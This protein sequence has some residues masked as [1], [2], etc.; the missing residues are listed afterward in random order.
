M[1]KCCRALLEKKVIIRYDTAVSKTIMAKICEICKKG[2][3]SGHHIKHKQAGGW[4][5][6]APKTNRKL[7]PNLRSIEVVSEAG[8]NVR[9]KVC[10]K[11]Y[12]RIRA[13]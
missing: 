8:K 10:M 9:I 4:A 6:K 2:T 13:L 11:C 12:K 3:V 7:V 1:S 5:L